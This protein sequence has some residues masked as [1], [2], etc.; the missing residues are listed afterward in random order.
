MTLDKM[1]YKAVHA[2]I[3][4]NGNM[5]ANGLVYNAANGNVANFPLE[6]GDLVIGAGSV[7]TM[8]AGVYRAETVGRDT[9]LPG[10]S[11]SLTDELAQ[12]WGYGDHKIL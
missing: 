12:N 2:A 7:G 6:E 1:K 11:K 8:Y 10:V 4:R 5:V 3:I 9:S